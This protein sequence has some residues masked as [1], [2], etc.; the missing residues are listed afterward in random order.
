MLVSEP[1]LSEKEF[2]HAAVIMVDY[3]E[4]SSSMGVVMNKLSD[5][6]L[7]ELLEDDVTGDGDIPVY[8]GGPMSTDRLFFIHTLGDIIPGSNEITDGLYVGGDFDAI[9]SYVNSGYPIEGCVRF[10]LGY[11]GWGP[12]QL[13]EE[14]GNHVWGV[15]KA[16]SPDVMLS[17][18]GD[19][20][21]HKC[22]KGLGSKFGWWRLH[23][24]YPQSN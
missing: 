3:S 6:S 16:L 20:Y 14:V 21:W 9:I 11:S 22:V 7:H 10:F 15:G 8:A 23:P 19:T 5:Y 1:F 24:E 13:D 18:N 2:R 4:E 17:G 12:G